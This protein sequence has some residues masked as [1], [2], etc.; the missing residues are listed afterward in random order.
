MPRKTA[1][2]EYIIKGHSDELTPNTA[3]VRSLDDESGFL[4]TANVSEAQRWAS[5]EAAL[6]A[7]QTGESNDGEHMFEIME[8]VS[9]AVV[10]A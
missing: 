9:L 8:G 4:F 10:T 3:Y 2:I 5:R 1:K 6:A 7:L